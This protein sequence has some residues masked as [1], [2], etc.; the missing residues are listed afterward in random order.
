MQTL[1]PEYPRNLTFT[2]KFGPSPMSPNELWTRPQTESSGLAPGC[3]VEMSME[4]VAGSVRRERGRD[5]Y[6]QRR[7]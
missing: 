1:G 3:Q 7:S 2:T 4:L 5:R 6:S